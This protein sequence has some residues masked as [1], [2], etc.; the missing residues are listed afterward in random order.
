MKVIRW[1]GCAECAETTVHVK[2]RLAPDKSPKWAG[3]PIPNVWLCSK[4][5]AMNTPAEG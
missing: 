4:C 2:H 3:W 5:A 1:L